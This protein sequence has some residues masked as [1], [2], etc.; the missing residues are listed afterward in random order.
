MVK[1]LGKDDHKESPKVKSVMA[2]YKNVCYEEYYAH[3]ESF[4]VL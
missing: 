4:M 1:F 3:V 2:L